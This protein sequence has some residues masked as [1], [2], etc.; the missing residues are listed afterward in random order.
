MAPLVS[1]AIAHVRPRRSVRDVRANQTP[2][3][4]LA[5]LQNR[6][7]GRV[8]R[9]LTRV[10]VYYY[11]ELTMKEIGATLDLSESRGSQMHSAIV[12][13]LQGQSGRRRPVFGT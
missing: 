5:A 6:C 1:V 13:R 2:S 3:R 4:S 9:L 7:C 8:I 10:V 11:E 12:Q